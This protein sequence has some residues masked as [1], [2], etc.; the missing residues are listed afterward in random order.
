MSIALRFSSVSRWFGPV[1]AVRDLDLTVEQGSVTVILGPNGAGKT[2]SFRL[3]TGVLAPS[4]GA[5]EVHGRDPSVDG[6][7]VRRRCGVVPPKPAMYDRLTG[8]ENLAY[9][10]R[11]Y[12]LDAPPIDEMAERFAIHHAL[13]QRVSG[14][15]TGMRTRLA[16]ARSLLHDP[17]LLLLDEP[18]SGLDPES[19]MAVRSLLFDMTEEGKTVVMSTHLLH[20]ADGTADQIVLMDRGAAWDVGSPAELVSRY[21]DGVR[22]HIDA[23]D[24]SLLTLAEAHPAVREVEENGHFTV[25]LESIDDLPE[26]VAALVAEGA[27]L[28]RVEPDTPTL[29]RLYFRMRARAL[30]SS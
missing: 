2:T 16:L 18:T 29:E 28:T 8:R 6:Q 14:Y 19:A 1:W 5:I 3:A 26:L 10:A 9:A 27:R 12:E 11:L 20:E 4:S 7:W 24:R 25:T 21:W 22:V 23:V 30:E 17:E 13:D 15:S